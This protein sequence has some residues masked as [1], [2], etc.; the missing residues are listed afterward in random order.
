MTMPMSHLE[1]FL[2]GAADASGPGVS[3]GGEGVRAGWQESPK[4][5]AGL[6]RN[7][8]NTLGSRW[9]SAALLHRL[10]EIE[11]AAGDGAEE[12]A[13]LELDGIAEGR[14]VHARE[15]QAHRPLALGLGLLRRVVELAGHA[16]GVDVAHQQ[17]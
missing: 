7:A 16:L 6:H 17:V 4:A 14:V 15:P 12:G 13:R 9:Q 10:A 8:A 3:L 11:R 2:A 1:N 5:P